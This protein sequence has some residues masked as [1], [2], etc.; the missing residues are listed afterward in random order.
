MYRTQRKIE[1]IVNKKGIIEPEP[2][3]KVKFHAVIKNHDCE[4]N[5]YEVTLRA[6]SEKVLIPVTGI[7]C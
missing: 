7:Q 2:M 1:N 6:E 5:V 3:H 4:K